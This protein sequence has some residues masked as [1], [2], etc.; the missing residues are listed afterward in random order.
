MS[1]IMVVL[2]VWSIR[3]LESQL[4]KEVF[5]NSLAVLRRSRQRFLA[6]LNRLFR[7]PGRA[8]VSQGGIRMDV[9]QS[10]VV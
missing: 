3:A 5:Y 1:I 4:G 7:P 10:G 8:P 6:R 2:V 9:R